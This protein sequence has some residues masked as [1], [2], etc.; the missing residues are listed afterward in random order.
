MTDIEIDE[1]ARG[2]FD[3]FKSFALQEY[4]EIDS[5]EEIEYCKVIAKRYPFLIPVYVWSGKINKDGEEPYNYSYIQGF[6]RGGWK[7]LF[8]KYCEKVKP[9]FDKLI[10]EARIETGSN[11]TGSPTIEELDEL[12]DKCHLP[13]IT[14]YKEKFGRMNVYWSSET[15]K[16][17][18]AENIAG[19]LSTVTC[20]MCGKVPRTS[21][22][23]HL[24]WETKGWISYYC[25]DCFKKDQV[26]KNRLS[27]R[28]QADFNDYVSMC[29]SVHP[30]YFITESWSKKDGH[31]KTF[32]KD[33]RDGW[34]EIDHV[35]NF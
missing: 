6:W 19:M 4:P 22:G 29:R 35:Q 12:R 3:T 21:S 23:K 2:D 30:K 9:E 11:L 13:Y 10:D 20:C 17:S 8:L 16:M 5:K 34:L 33:T 14:D 24:I 27:K 15:P 26:G 7:E 28:D 1:I 31:K 18:E 32:W 25:K